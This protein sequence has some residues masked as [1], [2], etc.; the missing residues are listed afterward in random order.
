[1]SEV[2]VK[3]ELPVVLII[4]SA[5]PLL[6]MLLALIPSLRGIWIAFNAPFLYRTGVS[7]YSVIGFSWL[8]TVVAVLF[9]TFLVFITAKFGLTYLPRAS[10]TRNHL[11]MVFTFILTLASLVFA[12]AGWDLCDEVRELGLSSG[13]LGF[14]LLLY[15]LT[16]LALIVHIL[17]LIGN[18]RRFTVKR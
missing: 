4:S 14:G 1:M 7:Y 18:Y 10:K 15:R 17:L 6:L 12:F 16:F 5:A 9:F 13:L 11:S 2:L 8:F 3:R